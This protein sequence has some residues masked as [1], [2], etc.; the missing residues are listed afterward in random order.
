MM[1]AQKGPGGALQPKSEGLIWGTE[2]NERAKGRVRER[3]GGARQPRSEEIKND[4]IIEK[5]A[6]IQRKSESPLKG[7]ITTKK[8]KGSSGAQ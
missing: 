7:T 6:K 4:A 5:G 8:S 2:T 1:G 3:K